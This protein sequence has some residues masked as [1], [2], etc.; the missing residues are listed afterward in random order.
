MGLKDELVARSKGKKAPAPAPA[1]TDVEGTAPV[2]EASTSVQNN[3]GVSDDLTLDDLFTEEEQPEETPTPQPASTPEP[4]PVPEPVPEPEPEPDPEPDFEEDSG[5]NF[6]SD[7]DAELINKYGVDDTDNALKDELLVLAKTTILK[8]VQDNF[9]SKLLANEA[10]KDLI[11]S[12]LNNKKFAYENRNSIL[13]SL[14]NEILE[15]DYH[16]SHYDEYK[17]RIFKSIIRDLEE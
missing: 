17:E 3:S 7:M 8:D 1:P 13:I 5:N 12:Y 10:M 11:D 4:E 2:E 15:N 9:E 6:S 14:I 16:H